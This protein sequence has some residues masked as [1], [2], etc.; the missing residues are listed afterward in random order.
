MGIDTLAVLL[1]GTGIGCFLI[2]GMIV[3][4][5]YRSRVLRSLGWCM[6]LLAIF[7]CLLILGVGTFAVQVG[8]YSL[9]GLRVRDDLLPVVIAIVAQTVGIYGAVGVIL[10]SWRNIERQLREALDR[11]E[12]KR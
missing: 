7:A 8:V 9:T 2:A 3:V 10:Y 12:E 6:T 1:A 11:K 4:A 5:Y